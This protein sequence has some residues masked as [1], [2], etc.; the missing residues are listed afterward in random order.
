MA[1]EVTSPPRTAPYIYAIF[2]MKSRMTLIRGKMPL[3]TLAQE[4]RTQIDHIVFQ[5]PVSSFSYPVPDHKFRH[6]ILKG[7]EGA[8]EFALVFV[9]SHAIYYMSRTGE[10][11]YYIYQKRRLGKILALG[12]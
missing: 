5:I 9:N 2:G 3:T 1:V 11:K 8:S 6:R 7:D 12:G 4:I 10:A